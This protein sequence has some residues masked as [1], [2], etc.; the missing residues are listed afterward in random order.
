MSLQNILFYKYD[1]HE[2]FW[3]ARSSFFI[4]QHR[5]KKNE[6]WPYCSLILNEH[7]NERM[8]WELI[9]F[10]DSTCAGFLFENRCERIP[11]LHLRPKTKF[12][13]STPLIVSRI[14]IAIQSLIPPSPNS[15]SNKQTE[16]KNNSTWNIPSLHC[17]VRT[18]KT[19]QK[20]RSSCVSCL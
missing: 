20:T 13:A 14:V 5:R 3:E 19:L 15:L 12:I 6:C 1:Y 10:S 18:T 7:P 16:K 9:L 8:H 11:F 2:L 17:S 4:T